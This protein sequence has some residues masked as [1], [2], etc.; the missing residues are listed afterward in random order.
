MAVDQTRIV[1]LALIAATMA[2]IDDASSRVDV[3]RGR[4]DGGQLWRTW[5]VAAAIVPV[6]VVWMGAVLYPGWAQVD[7]WIDLLGGGL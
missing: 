2:W 7:D 4:Q 6:P 3:D 5:A 1:A